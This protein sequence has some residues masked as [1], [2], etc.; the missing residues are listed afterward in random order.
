MSDLQSI[1]CPVGIETNAAV[2]ILNEI[3]IPQEI[4]EGEIRIGQLIE[5]KDIIQILIESGGIKKGI[6]IGTMRSI[7]VKKI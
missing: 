7:N 4:E 6:I 5:K 3:L 1:D 2:G